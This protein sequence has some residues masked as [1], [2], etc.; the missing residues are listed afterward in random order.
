ASRCPR[1][2]CRWTCARLSDPW[3]VGRNC[4]PRPAGW[5]HDGAPARS[6]VIDCPDPDALAAF[7]Q[8]L[9]GMVRVNDDGGWVVIG[10]APD[11]P[12][13]A[14]QRVDDF[15]PPT[16]AGPRG[17]ATA[18]PRHRGGRPGRGRGRGGGAGR[19]PPGRRWRQVPGVRRSGRPPVLP[20]PALTDRYLPVPGAPRPGQEG[21]LPP[22]GPGKVREAS[23]LMWFV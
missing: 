14:F 16:L 23:G 12:G 11:R 13:L 20:G 21:P 6:V 5:A 3:R 9:L 2:C 22:Q 7:Y 1:C 10:D 18:P 19:P 8:R 4:R 17:A 15:R